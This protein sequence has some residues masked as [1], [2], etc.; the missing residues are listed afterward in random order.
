MNL[1]ISHNHPEPETRE[2]ANDLVELLTPVVKAF[3]TDQG[4]LACDQAMQV[5]GGAGYTKDWGVEQ[6]LRDC[7]I[8]RIYEG[9]NL[10][11]IHI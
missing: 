5:L 10:S 9:T 3:I 1:D 7:R 2:S 4:F 8:A 11:L 6:L